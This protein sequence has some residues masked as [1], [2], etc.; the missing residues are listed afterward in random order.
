MGQLILF[1]AIQGLG[2]GG[3][4][5]V[6][7]AII[8]DV[9][10]PRDRG[11]YQGCSAPSSG[12]R[13]S[14]GR[15]SAA[16]SSTHLSLALGLL[17]QPAVG[18]V[19]LVATAPC[20]PPG[21][22]AASTQIDYRGTSCSPRASRPHAASPRWAG[23][24]DA[25][26]SGRSS[27]R[28]ARPSSCLVVFVLV[29]RRAAEPVL[30]PQLF[31][32]QGVPHR[33]RGRLRRRLRDVRGHHLPA[34]VPAGGRGASMP[35]E[36]GLVLLPMM[37]GLLL[38]RLGSGQLISRTGHYKVF[39]VAGTAVV[40][41]GSSCSRRMGVDTGALGRRSCSCSASGWAGDAGARDRRAERVATRTWA[42][43]R[44]GDVLPLD[45]QLSGSPCSVPCSGARLEDCAGE[46][47]ACHGHRT[48]RSPRLLSCV[49][50]QP[51]G[52]PAGGAG[53]VGGVVRR[54]D[55]HRVPGRRTHRPGGVRDGLADP[56]A[57]LCAPPPPTSAR[58][59]GWRLNARRSRS[60]A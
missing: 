32:E 40:T 50:R 49:S 46:G 26:G 28:R 34:A 37:V 9:V 56:R 5:V 7:Q 24:R 25:W 36:S 19:A 20:C 30:P 57:A 53:L 29:E 2:G 48:V 14:P 18:V 42:R 35:T 22:G 31:A 43:R 27:A 17:R 8:G 38:D 59:S 51:V 45:R 6:A 54:G 15:C 52:L 11:Q 58:A 44:V 47:R 23:R 3:L 4:I 33:G 10:R 12:S 21:A 16:S 1:R 13:A 60:S 41:S 39:P 55:P